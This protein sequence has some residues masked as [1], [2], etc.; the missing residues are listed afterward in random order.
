MS[1]GLVPTYKPLPEKLRLGFSNIHDLGIFAKEKIKAGA[2]LGMSHLKLGEKIIRTP[3]GGFLNHA[4][5]PNCSKTKLRYTN[6]DISKNK[7]N[8]VAWN[9]IVI[10]DIQVD[11]ELTVKYEWYKPTAE[12]AQICNVIF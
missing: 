11:E 2:N 5:D 4:D 8:Y 12:V 10:K 3:L 7:F 9:L 6:E 1:F